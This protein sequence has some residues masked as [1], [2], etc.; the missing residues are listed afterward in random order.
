MEIC[1]HAYRI[2]GSESEF[3]SIRIAKPSLR[4]TLSTVAWPFPDSSIFSNKFAVVLIDFSASTNSH[5]S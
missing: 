2:L 5:D 3:V 4:L 1:S